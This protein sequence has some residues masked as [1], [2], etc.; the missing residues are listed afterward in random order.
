MQP[1][2]PTLAELSKRYEVILHRL[3]GFEKGRPF[4]V[5][6]NT[7]AP[8]P[9]TL[10]APISA[11][12]EPVT[13]ENGE[14]CE[15]VATFV[16]AHISATGETIADAVAM[17]K[18]RM[19]GQFRSL[20]KAPVEQLG[21]IPRQQLEALRSVMRAQRNDYLRR[22]APPRSLNRLSQAQARRG[23]RCGG[24][25]WRSRERLRPRNTKPRCT[26]RGWFVVVDLEA[27]HSFV[28]SVPA[29]PLTANPPVEFA[30]I[31]LLPGWWFS[32]QFPSAQ[33]NHTTIGNTGRPK[34][35]HPAT[36][37]RRRDGACRSGKACRL[38]PTLRAPRKLFPE[39]RVFDRSP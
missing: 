30:S 39:I 19:A 34:T 8:H 23:R 22:L 24:A 38:R 26:Q 1:E 28:R 32:G 31:A 6:I 4:A 27:K 7:F 21:T 13:D 25:W 36:T 29:P 5:P 14:V 11:L 35:A 3:E 12:M 33:E 9:F 10:I 15:Y 20:T 16:N 37:P 18:D 17:L 2:L